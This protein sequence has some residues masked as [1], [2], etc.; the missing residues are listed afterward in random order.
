M[1]RDFTDEMARLT[2][3]LQLM[4]R[5]WEEHHELKTFLHCSLE[6][7]I[8]VVTATDLISSFQTTENLETSAASSYWVVVVVSVLVP[9][10]S[11]PC[12]TAAIFRES[13]RKS[14]TI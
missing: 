8:F 3:F 9:V 7:E 5:W 11:R 1:A 12:G 2:G 13:E 6:R 4:S 10:D 14:V